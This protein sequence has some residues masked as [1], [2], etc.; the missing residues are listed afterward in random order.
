MAQ[1]TDEAAEDQP[2]IQLLSQTT[3]EAGQTVQRAVDESGDII[4]T[5]LDNETGTPASEDITGKITNLAAEEEYQND[6]GQTVRLVKEEESGR[7]IRLTLGEDGNILDLKFPFG[8]D[9]GETE[10]AIEQPGPHISEQAKGED[11]YATDAA[12]RKA[13]EMGVDLSQVEGSG[14]QGRIVIADVTRAARQG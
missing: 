1:R 10:E 12:R 11:P 5:T 3:N 2:E 4:E 9:E 6:K 14:T 8:N 7:L 13:E